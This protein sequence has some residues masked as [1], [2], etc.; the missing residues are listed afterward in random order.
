MFA[1]KLVRDGIL[2]FNAEAIQSEVQAIAKLCNVGAHENIVA[3]LRHGTLDS[4][5]YYFFDMELCDSN[6][7]QYIPRL[8]ELSALEKMHTDYL[9][10]PI[11]DWNKKVQDI[12]IIMQ[13]IASGVAYI[14]L[15]GMIHRDLK[16]R[17][18]TY[19]PPVIHN[20][21]S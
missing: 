16:P 14:H 11:V 8:W 13:H 7:E 21:C 10:R 4:S 12:W 1:R 2:D 9:D 18:S 3:M 19:T 6:L 15:H 5:P 20:I 17:N